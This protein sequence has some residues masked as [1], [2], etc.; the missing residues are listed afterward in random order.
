MRKLKI[1]LVV[2]VFIF[3]SKHSF[4]L[5]TADVIKLKQVGISDDLISLIIKKPL[6]TVDEI[7]KLKKA[8]ISDQT[9]QK[10]IEREER[11][12]ARYLGITRV[13][14]RADGTEVIIYGSVEPPPWPETRYYHLNTDSK[15]LK[16]LFLN[17]ERD[18]N[19]NQEQRRAWGILKNLRLYKRIN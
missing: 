10:M 16:T 1:F 8:G 18:S 4:S 7:I 11:E 17:I 6:L 19:L 13:R 5:I 14:K 9:I 2:L 15:Y 3:I 12:R